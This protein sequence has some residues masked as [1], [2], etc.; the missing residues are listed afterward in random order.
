VIKRIRSSKEKNTDQL[1][2]I[3]KE[4]G[5][6]SASL[7]GQ[8]GVD[9][10][11]YLLKNT[12]S[13]ELQRILLPVVIA[14]TKKGEIERADFAGY[15]DRLRLS[16]G[17][18]QLFGT[19][20]TIRNGFLV[21]YPIA[22]EAQ[23]DER[24]RQ[25]GL[26][27][28]R[29]YIRAMERIYRLPLLK[30]TGEITNAFAEKAQSSIFRKTENTL[31]EGEAVAED[32]VVRIDT[33]LVNLSVNVYNNKLKT[34]V[35]TLEQ[36][37]FAIFEDGHQEE[38]AF[39]AS[40]EVPCDL[41]LL[42]DLSGSTSSKRNLI[43]QTTKRFIEAARPS[44]RLALVTF[45]SITNI[46]SPLTADRKQLL[47]SAAKIEGDGGS[48]VWD[49]LK[50][51]L[52]QVVGPRT[53]DRRRAVVFM[54][55]GADNAL[56]SAHQGSR[57]LFGDLV[58]TVRRDDTSI[59]PIYLDTEGDDSYSKRIYENAR[60]TLAMLAEESGG[61]Y[62]K[63]RKI[64]DLGEVYAQVIEDLGKVYS[65]GYKPTNAKRDGSWRKVQI[66]ILNHRD[67][68]TQS[69]PGYYAR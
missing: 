26:A 47:E 24:R 33:N 57:I 46:V 12:A 29:E 1:C 9:A 63:A 27:P 20:A 7:V 28:L 48:H 56:A 11:F 32:E 66:Q 17:L 19:E 25:Y 43:R 62:Y 67:L 59:I 2:A 21:L 69:R 44:D 6:P 30:S 23:V 68:M 50:F 49:A 5:W 54:T 18:K 16:S 61:L 40:S 36:K 14:A 13:F 8:N 37:D 55:D 4:F 64:E 15:L 65:L 58:E 39:F 22:A 52:D 10:A 31:F 51:T 53:L 41:V 45:S 34:H 60:K 3:F 42:I 35:G 38:I